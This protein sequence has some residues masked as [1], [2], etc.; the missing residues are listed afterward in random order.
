MLV[1]KC[2]NMYNLWRIKFIIEKKLEVFDFST[3]NMLNYIN[4]LC[5]TKYMDL[6][7]DPLFYFAS[8]SSWPLKWQAIRNV[9]WLSTLTNGPSTKTWFK[10]FLNSPSIIIL[11]ISLEAIYRLSSKKNNKTC[12]ILSLF[13]RNERDPSKWMIDRIIKYFAQNINTIIVC[14][15]RKRV[16]LHIV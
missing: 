10:I 4:I 2:I 12:R 1:Q 13:S 14:S 15:R 9:D 7:C 6:T 5:S 11:H 8:R 16:M 3:L